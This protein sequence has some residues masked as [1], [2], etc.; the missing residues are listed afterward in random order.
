MIK[1]LDNIRSALLGVFVKG[2]TP[3]TFIDSAADSISFNGSVKLRWHP[4]SLGL[5]LIFD[6]C[7]GRKN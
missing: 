3:A 1:I 5:F 4:N 7:V 2:F 6:N